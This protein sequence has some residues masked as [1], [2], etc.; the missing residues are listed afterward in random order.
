MRPTS[1][2]MLK[3]SETAILWALLGIGRCQQAGLV[4]PWETAEDWTAVWAASGQVKISITTRSSQLVVQYTEAE[5]LTNSP[6]L[7]W[8]SSEPIITALTWL[9]TL[10]SC[11]EINLSKCYQTPTLTLAILV[12]PGPLIV[13]RLLKVRQRKSRRISFRRATICPNFKQI[14]T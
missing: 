1:S 2:P 5:A 13:A 6:K 7:R 3:R 11:L 10:S 8:V 9:L 14:S 12:I 4:V